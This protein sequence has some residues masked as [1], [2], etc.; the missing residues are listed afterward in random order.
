MILP[1]SYFGPI[2]E[3]AFVAQN[4]F[5]RYEAKENFV[6]QSYRNR[7]VIAGANGILRLTV[8]LVLKSREKTPMEAIQIANIEN[9]QAHHWKSIISAYKN[10]PFFYYYEPYLAPLFTQEQNSLLALNMKTNEVIQKCLQLSCKTELTTEF[11]PYSSQDLR[12]LI[13]PKKNPIISTPRYIQVFE[14]RHG[15][16]PNLSILDLLFNEGP[17]ATLYLQ[18]LPLGAY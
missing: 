6:K 3:Y 18:S 9:W 17:N 14:E 12:L 1:I 11:T 15:F 2:E 16:M 13:S 4:N 10:S 7:F 8:P 5:L